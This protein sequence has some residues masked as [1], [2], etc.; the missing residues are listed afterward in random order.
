MQQEA[1]ATAR[2]ARAS[3]LAALEQQREEDRITFGE[4]QRDSYYNDYLSAANSATDYV[5]STIASEQA[6]ADLLGIEYSITEEGKQE[7]INNYFSSLWTEGDQSEIEKLFAEFG[8]VENFGGFTVTR[9]EDSAAESDALDRERTPTTSSGIRPT[10][11][12]APSRR[13]IATGSNKTLG[14]L[15]TLGGG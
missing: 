3:E 8:E 2:S 10:R 1:A 11:G 7:R 12:G 6:N 5:N 14:S 13:S 15:A 9:G 4:N